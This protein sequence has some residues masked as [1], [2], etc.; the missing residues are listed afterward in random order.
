M[1]ENSHCPV[2]SKLASRWGGTGREWMQAGQ[3][4]YLTDYRTGTLRAD[5][6]ISLEG[7]RNGRQRMRWGIGVVQV[8]RCAVLIREPISATIL[9][10]SIIIFPICIAT[11]LLFKSALPL[12]TPFQTL[13]NPRQTS[14][15]QYQ[16]LFTWFNFSS[17]WEIP[18]FILSKF[19]LSEQTHKRNPRSYNK[20]LLPV[21]VVIFY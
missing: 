20:E 17:P 10:Q 3:V 8:G 14:A 2:F 11:K 12:S 7:D 4:R 19:K 16:D 15:I 6:I 13:T 5:Y 18:Y 21:F 9:W 1:L